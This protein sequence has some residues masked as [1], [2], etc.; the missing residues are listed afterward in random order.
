MIWLHQRLRLLF[1]NNKRILLQLSSRIKPILLLLN[2]RFKLTHH[3]DNKHHLLT[4]INNPLLNN[5]LSSNLLN[6][7]QLHNNPLSN[8][9]LHN[10]QLNNNQHLNN[11]FRPHPRNQLSNNKTHLQSKDQNLV[12]LPK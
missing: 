1:H 6:S 3:K 8:N 4:T 7:S 11:Q 12:L 10:N 2:N 9:Q 5:L